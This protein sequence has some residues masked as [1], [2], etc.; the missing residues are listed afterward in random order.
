MIQSGGDLIR[1]RWQ[2]ARAKRISAQ[3]EMKKGR[4]DDCTFFVNECTLFH[5][6]CTI[7]AMDTMIHLPTGHIGIWTDSVGAKGSAVVEQ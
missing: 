2:H 6:E 4:L 1:E 5:N 3:E 7:A